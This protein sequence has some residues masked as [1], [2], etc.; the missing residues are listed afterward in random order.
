MAM[1]GETTGEAD[2]LSPRER[3]IFDCDEA[4]RTPTRN[5]YARVFTSGMVALD[6]NVLLN[7]YRSNERTRKDTLAVLGRLRHQLWIPHQVLTEFWRNRD[8][9]SVRGHHHTKARE[10]ISALDKVSRSANDALSRWM[11]DVHLN[12]DEAVRQRIEFSR[13]SLSESLEQLKVIV[14][15]Q[16]EKDALEGTSDTHTDPV[17]TELEPLLHGRIGSPLPPDEFETALQEAQRR[18]NEKIPPGYADFESKPP[19]QA[20]GDYML[21]IQ[22]IAE[23]AARQCDVLLVTGDIKDDWWIP[24][25]GKVSARP[26]TELGVEI[27]KRTNS[28][29]FMLTPSQLLVKA[30]DVFG[31]QVD[32]R[33]VS[34]LA[35]TERGTANDTLPKDFIPAIWTR[36]LRAHET[37]LD[38]TKGALSSEYK[39][40]Y[41]SVVASFAR[42]EIC[43]EVIRR[44]GMITRIAGSEYPILD[45]RLIIPYRLG[46]RTMS[47]TDTRLRLQSS[48]RLEHIF[49]SYAELT[50]VFGLDGDVPGHV[51]STYPLT[52]VLLFF[53]ST[54]DEGILSLDYANVIVQPDG[55]T[56]GY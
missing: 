49:R 32:E 44:G 27:R 26:R 46:N 43:D 25:D 34:D 33:S 19:R 29:F 36:L 45:G 7:L 2:S 9:P 48:A 40:V 3:G 39:K 4:Y 53:S 55:F 14:K 12:N 51:S 23:A 54:A 17:L 13:S 50:G 52:A 6:T 1:P 18:A 15:E 42:E 16:A 21:W 22:L 41:G 38:A 20:A 30:N 35:T 37:A 24:G 28:N 5:D 56:W 31:M 47:A 10:A 8:L 11:K